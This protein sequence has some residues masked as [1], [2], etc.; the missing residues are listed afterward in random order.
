MS[1]TV[2][3]TNDSC[4][5]S[6]AA[7]V[8]RGYFLDPYVC[9]FVSTIATRSPIINR[10]Y[11]IRAYSVQALVSYLLKNS[12]FVDEKGNKVFIKQ[13]VSLGAGFDTMYFRLRD[14]GATKH[15]VNYVEVDAPNVLQRKRAVIEQHKLLNKLVCLGCK[16]F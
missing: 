12:Y 7:M 1:V 4:T 5:M 2:Q 10:G 16:M 15:V 8:K 3:G 6:K 11:F 14:S 9:K 13:I